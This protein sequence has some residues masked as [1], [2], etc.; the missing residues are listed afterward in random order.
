[1]YEAYWHLQAKP[2]DSTSD[3]RFYY[4]S[5][6]HQAALLKLRYA[7][8]SRHAAATLSGA[9]GVGK[10][11]LLYSLSR[12]LPE[13]FTPIITVV[14]PQLA[15]DQ[16]LTYLA[17]RLAGP[18]EGAVGACRSLQRIERHFEQNAAAGRHA[19]ILIDEA[20]LL[21][22]S[23]TL[24]TIRLLT[25]LQHDGRPAATF[26]LAG[27]PPLLSTLERMPELDERFTVKCF[28][29]RLTT[30]ET[31]SYIAHRLRA[32]GASQPIFDAEAVQ[33]IHALAHG[34]PR[35][36]NRLCDLALVIGFAEERTSIG[37][38]QVEAV[39][40]ELTPLAM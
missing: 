23:A 7:I 9:S 29:P 22:D 34:S 15:P 24:E 26:V 25:N 40:D 33:T 39:A 16:L 4:P 38:A 20:H 3:A 28:V 31:A 5:A 30:D 1:M 37:R 10:T 17:D 6:D 32:A 27:L 21:A 35:R 13:S 12:Q 8:E 11:L 18:S 36:I 14:F 2:F 19:V